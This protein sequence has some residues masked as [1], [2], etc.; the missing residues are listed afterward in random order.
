MYFKIASNVAVSIE[1][2][3]KETHKPLIMWIMW[4]SLGA[5]LPESLLGDHDIPKGTVALG[6]TWDLALQRQENT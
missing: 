5:A 2:F 1:V 6:G 4:Y 3:L